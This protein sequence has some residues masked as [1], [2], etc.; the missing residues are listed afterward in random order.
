[1]GDAPWGSQAHHGWSV[2]ASAQLAAVCHGAFASWQAALT[3]AM[4][5]RGVTRREARALAALVVA[6]TEGSLMLARAA[7]D[8]APLRT[9]ARELETVLRDRVP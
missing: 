9:V 1:M 2:A 7:R 6:A 5:A 8:A 3:D 4:T